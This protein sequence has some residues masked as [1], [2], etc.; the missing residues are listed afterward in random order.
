[1]TVFKRYE[2]KFILTRVQYRSV[3]S[4]ITDHM[5]KDAYCKK[6][7]FYPVCN[8]Y[9]DT[10]DY[11]VAR[12]SLSRPYYKEKLRLRSYGFSDHEKIPMFLEVKKKIHKTVVK[13]R[14]EMSLQEAEQF[15]LYGFC[16]DHASYMTRQIL[17]EIAVC[18]SR[19][20][21]MPCLRINYERI[22]YY[23]R[24][25]PDFRLTFDRNIYAVDLCD[26][27]KKW[28]LLPEDFCLMEAKASGAMPLWFAK[29]LSAQ[30]IYSSS[31]SKYRRAFQ[32]MTEGTERIR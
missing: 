19:K 10:E 13:R 11:A 14:V 25:Q 8:Q 17:G 12:A 9:F 18:L 32:L 21:M 29:L 7:G 3:I 20:K 6:Q 16:P 26:Q 15:F 31:F 5:E 2:K 4:D 23:D 22:A 1:M 28:M 30:Q 27:D 24:E